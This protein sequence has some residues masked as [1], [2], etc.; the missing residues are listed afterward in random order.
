MAHMPQCTRSLV[1]SEPE[2]SSTEDQE[3]CEPKIFSPTKT[4]RIEDILNQILLEDR[5]PS[6]RDNL[7]QEAL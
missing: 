5:V 4:N 1:Q 6:V 2:S 3:C 7:E